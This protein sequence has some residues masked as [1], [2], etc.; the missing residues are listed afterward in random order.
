MFECS[1]EQ[2][3]PR[4]LLK[5]KRVINSN[6]TNGQSGSTTTNG[7]ASPSLNSKRQN[8]LN[9]KSSGNFKDEVNVDNLDFT[10]KILHTS[11]HPKDN[12]IA[13]AA[14]NNLYLFYNKETN[15]NSSTFTPGTS[16]N[17]SLNGFNN[18]STTNAST[19][20]TSSNA[21]SNN[22]FILCNN[23]NSTFNSNISN[24]NSNNLV[25][26]TT[27]STL[28]NTTTQTANSSG[29]NINNGGNNNSNDN[30]SSILQNTNSQLINNQIT[31][32]TSFYTASS[33]SSST[34]PSSSASISPSSTSSSASTSPPQSQ[35]SL[36]S[37]NT[38]TSNPTSM[39]L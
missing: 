14:T 32:N 24:S 3:K 6:L 9:G 7:V 5:P 4:Q 26:T 16:S 15:P 36:A 10:K 1:R 19:N 12:I 11:W 23:T 28:L 34:S 39:T 18:A 35:P 33:S 20:N 2:S 27:N 25:N 13:I 17:I 31:L 29:A 30:T 8:A 37:I 21:S 38:V 22:S